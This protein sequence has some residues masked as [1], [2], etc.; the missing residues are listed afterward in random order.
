VKIVRGLQAWSK[1]QKITTTFAYHC[2]CP[3]SNPSFLLPVKPRLSQP[4]ILEAV[5]GERSFAGYGNVVGITSFSRYLGPYTAGRAPEE[6]KAQGRK[7]T[8]TGS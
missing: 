7:L 5:C 1:N 8:L 2:I 4:L 6:T 3:A